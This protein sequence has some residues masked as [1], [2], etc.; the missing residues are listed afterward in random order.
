[1]IKEI[2]S[3]LDAYGYNSRKSLDDLKNF[4]LHNP[5]GIGFLDESLEILQKSLVFD[6]NIYLI[7]ENSSQSIFSACLMYHF[8]TKVSKFVELVSLDQSK[9]LLSKKDNGLLLNFCKKNDFDDY[10]V[11]QFNI[12]KKEKSIYSKNINI[13]KNLVVLTLDFIRCFN[14]KKLPKGKRIILKEE[15]VITALF[16]M[17]QD[18][19]QNEYKIII[20]SALPI[21][22]QTNILGL[23]LYLDACAFKEFPSYQELAYYINLLMFQ[24]H[25]KKEFN[26]LTTFLTSKNLMVYDCILKYPVDYL[27]DQA[28]MSRNIVTKTFN[29]FSMDY[30]IMAHLLYH[31]E[32]I[33]MKHYF[34]VQ[35]HGLKGFKVLKNDMM[36]VDSYLTIIGKNQDLIAISNDLNLKITGF[37]VSNGIKCILYIKNIGN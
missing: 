22:F 11:L 31:I 5:Y 6:K 24:I 27:F 13:H 35:I 2:Q 29:I 21:M 10:D 19:L 15:L 30:K 28:I 23:N 4:S 9:E 1:M 18:E 17:S 37:M 25:L 34:N 12:V 7:Y 36:I 26:D 3:I 20:K 32:P 8:L 33:P 16:L 14:L